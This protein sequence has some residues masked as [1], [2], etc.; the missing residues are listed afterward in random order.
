MRIAL[1][2]AITAA[3]APVHEAFVK[4]WPKAEYTDLLD[5]AL[6]VDREREGELT[7]AMTRRI[8]AL[9]EYAAGTGAAGILF[10]CTAF[11][12][13]IGA[14]AAARSPLPVLKPNEAMF[15][16]AMKAGKRI[17]MLATFQPAVA[18]LE[19]EFRA[20]AALRGSPATIETVCVESA[21]QALR[22]G[23]FAMHDRILA[24]A[25]PKLSHCDAVVLAHFSTARAE[26][27]VR[28]HLGCPVLSAPSA[29][30]NRLKSMVA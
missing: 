7:P 4:L 26:E 21:M 8:G 29:A 11:G 25:A 23:D 20:L 19:D 15:D 9:A 6:L 13:A 24:A 1:I 22:A 5:T 30:V 10:T 16:A 2:H 3:I 27:A 17:G 28:A 18:S 14:A 12:E